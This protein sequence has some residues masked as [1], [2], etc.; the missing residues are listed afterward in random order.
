MLKEHDAK[1]KAFRVFLFI[2]AGL[3]NAFENFHNSCLSIIGDD[4]AKDYG[5]EKSRIGLLSSLYFYLNAVM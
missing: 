5:V 3:F 1:F 4:I 2:N